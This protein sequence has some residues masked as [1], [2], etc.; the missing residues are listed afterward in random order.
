MRDT[1]GNG[2]GTFGTR[3]DPP[4]F[5]PLRQEMENVLEGPEYKPSID[6]LKRRAGL[7]ALHS[8]QE[9]AAASAGGREG[10][11]VGLASIGSRRVEG[12]SEEGGQPTGGRRARGKRPP[13]ASEAAAGGSEIPALETRETRH[14]KKKRAG[15]WHSAE[16]AC[17]SVG[18]LSLSEDKLSPA[19]AAGSNFL[20][21]DETARRRSGH[22]NAGPSNVGSRARRSRS[23]RSAD[24]SGKPP[25]AK[26][27]EPQT[28]GWR[29]RPT[30]GSAPPSGAVDGSKLPL[31]DDDDDDEAGGSRQQRRTLPR[32][33][34][35]GRGG[36]DAARGDAPLKLEETVAD[37]PAAAVAAAPK[38]TPA[39]AA[40]KSAASGFIPGSSAALNQQAFHGG[41]PSFSHF[42]AAHQRPLS[43]VIVEEIW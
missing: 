27:S 37:K 11:D 39:A 40:Y 42:L 6:R 31:P 41:G 43:C 38:A 13:S 35:A 22:A 30:Q 12:P 24:A 28:R 8:E 14:S 5:A 20:S 33:D 1:H 29:C 16:G 36:G 25:P 7:L 10:P 3:T 9:A 32:S 18:S 19:L 15:S 23:L 34:A 2:Y 17:L 4:L 21:E 26:A